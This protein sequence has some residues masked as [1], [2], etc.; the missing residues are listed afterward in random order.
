MIC[1]KCKRENT[2][3]TKWCCYCGASLP[4]LPNESKFYKEVAD[5][6]GKQVPSRQE[7]KTMPQEKKSNFN[8]NAFLILLI[9]LLLATGGTMLLLRSRRASSKT[10]RD[11]G[12]TLLAVTPTPAIS[13]PQVF[14]SPTTS[15]TSPP[16]SVPSTMPTSAPSATPTPTPIPTP[17]P[18][19]TPTPTPTPT[20]VHSYQ[21]T[22]IRQPTCT[23]DGVERATCSC[24][25][26]ITSGISALGHSYVNDACV[27]CGAINPNHV[28]HIYDTVTIEEPATC[29][30]SGRI[31]SR[32]IICGHIDY[33]K[34]IPA[35]GHNYVNG[36]CTR[37]GSSEPAH[38]HRF[39]GMIIQ[40][41]PSCTDE[42]YEQKTCSIC[43]YT[44]TTTL[45]ALGHNYVNHVCTRCGKI[46]EDYIVID[47]PNEEIS[48]RHPSA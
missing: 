36:V 10:D 24:G 47:D 34:M 28:Y 19:L 45:P 6:P 13:S 27:R 32:C 30:E 42:G 44:E 38:T 17:T 5:K 14:P 9:A 21:W 25:D 1:S 40:C 37:C 48:Y 46:E 23:E 2:E 22:T 26:T 43:G 35:L 3:N 11:G 8:V 39:D 4:P 20:H 41:L 16:S 15:V 29:A 18:T 7:K 12:V 33:F 31:G